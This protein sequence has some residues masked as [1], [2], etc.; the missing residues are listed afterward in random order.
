MLLKPIV[1]TSLSFLLLLHLG[2]TA[3]ASEDVRMMLQQR[4]QFE[5]AVHAFTQDGTATVLSTDRSARPH[6]VM[7]A[8]MIA[9]SLTNSNDKSTLVEPR[10]L[11]LQAWIRAN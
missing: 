6:A 4:L 7:Q 11:F 1:C 2:R 3:S 5:N 8:D 9:I 10:V